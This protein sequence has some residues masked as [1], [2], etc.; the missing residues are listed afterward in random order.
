[1]NIEE[2]LFPNSGKL[3]IIEGMPCATVVDEELDPFHCSFVDTDLVEIT[4]ENISYLVL[5]KGHLEKLLKLMDEA[6]KYH[7]RDIIDGDLVY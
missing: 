3:L 6:N 5:S 4:T 2:V 7:E 1:M